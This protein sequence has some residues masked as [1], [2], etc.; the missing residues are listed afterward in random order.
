MNRRDLLVAVATPILIAKLGYC[1]HEIDSNPP[2]T[3]RIVTVAQS[4]PADFIG[5]DSAVLQ[6]AAD[7]LKPGD[8][9]EIA[10]GTYIMVNSLFLPSRITVRGKRGQTILRKSPGVESRLVEDGDYGENQ[11]RVAEPEKFRPGMGISISDKLYKSDW[12]VSVATIRS[13]EGRLLYID[14]MLLRD[15]SAEKQQASVHNSIP[16]LC[17]IEADGVVVENLIVDGNKAENAYIDGCRGGAIYIYR[18]KNVVIRNC[19][20]RNY[21]G[22]GISYQI[23]DNI[24]VVN[25]ESHGHTGYGIHPG[26]GTTH[27]TVKG[28]RIHDNGEAGLFL[29]WRVRDGRVEDNSIENNG[30]YG[31]SIGHKDTD[32]VFVNNTISGNGVS[33]VYFR[34]ETFK[35]SA[36]RNR[37]SGNKVLNNGDA[38]EGYGFYIEPLAGD[39]TIS[40]NQIL[41]TRAGKERTQRYGVYKSAGVGDVKINDNEM[42]GHIEQ[43]VFDASQRR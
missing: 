18:S 32:N 24:E 19:V 30:K 5:A 36:H 39:L 2:R 11:L 41:D 43:D 26:A 33:G 35:N 4:P 25:C 14:P 38:K 7:S 28:C 37:F 40:N 6:K 23:T 22:D 34:K 10:S 9:M 21:N 17:A 42:E 29:C 13:N 8:T 27:S 31:I 3:E 15:Y 16:I 12:D 20:A 1:S